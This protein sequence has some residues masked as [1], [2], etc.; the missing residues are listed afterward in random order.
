VKGIEVWTEAVFGIR[1]VKATEK[2]KIRVQTDGH[3]CGICVVNAI[4]VYI[5]GGE[6]FTG[7]ARFKHHLEQ[8]IEAADLLLDSGVCSLPIWHPPTQA[9]QPKQQ[10]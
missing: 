5:H 6:I 2:Y 9:D 10:G 7:R 1:F 4:K 3:S 8:F